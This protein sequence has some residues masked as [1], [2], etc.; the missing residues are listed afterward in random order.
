RRSLG[1]AAGRS[2][3]GRP[4]PC[5]GLLNHAPRRRGGQTEERPDVLTGKMVRVRY[6]RDRIIPYFLDPADEQAQLVAEQLLELYRR[7]EG[8]TRGEFEEGFAATSGDA[9]STLLHQGL[10][11]RPEDRCELDVIAG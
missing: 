11:K 8:R 1:A 9:P 7:Y 10:A 5:P 3:R 6:A 4:H 2:R